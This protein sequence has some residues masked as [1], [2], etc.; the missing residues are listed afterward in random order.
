MDKSLPTPRPV[1]I[2][3]WMRANVFQLTEHMQRHGGNVLALGSIPIGIGH[4]REGHGYALEG[5]ILDYAHGPIL[6]ASR[7]GGDAVGRLELESIVARG[8][9]RR[10]VVIDGAIEHHGGIGGGG[11]GGCNCEGQ[12]KLGGMGLAAE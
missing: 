12:Q 11:T 5:D 6:V 4:V 2:H 8:I 7:L 3:R 10:I 1:L 9:G